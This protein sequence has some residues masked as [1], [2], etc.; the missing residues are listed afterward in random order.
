MR[1]GV[2][3]GA[4]LAFAFVACFVQSVVLPG[5][6]LACSCVEPQ[7]LAEIAAT[8]N[9]AVVAGTVGQALPDRTPL[10]ID[11]WFHGAN[12]SDAVWLNTGSQ[13]ISSCDIGMS[14][15]QRWLLVLYPADTGMYSAGLCSPHAML[16]TPEGEALF[17]EAAAVFGAG[18]PIPSPSPE[19]PASI[20]A[21][22]WLGGI[23]WVGGA[24]GAALLLFGAL[25][26]LAR[27]KPEA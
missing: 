8:E 7:P 21:S 11:T 22:P 18:Q 1:R 27:R 9:V 20:D 23:A 12:P 6:V 19:P 3:F 2:S 15:G 10:G 26:L 4:A 17:E 24:V 25:F 14:A 5:P 13:M 16:G